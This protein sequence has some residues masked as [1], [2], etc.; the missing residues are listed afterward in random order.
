MG[1]DT[2]TS[3]RKI[4]KTQLII[5]KGAQHPRLLENEIPLHSIRMAKILKLTTPKADVDTGQQELSFTASKNEKWE[6][7]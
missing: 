4:Y 1:K 7:K 5:W 6:M 2:D 3:P